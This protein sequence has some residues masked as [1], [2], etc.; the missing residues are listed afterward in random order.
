VSV[1]LHAPAA[2]PRE[3]APGTHFVEG[4]VD[5]RVGLDDMEKWKFF[6]LPGLELPPLLD[7]QPIAIRYTDWVIPADNNFILL[8]NNWQTQV[9]DKIS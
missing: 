8:I 5:P 7:V 4:W 1:Q 3:R 6:T 2:S 9:V